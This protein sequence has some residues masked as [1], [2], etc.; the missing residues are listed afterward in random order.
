MKAVAATAVL[1]VL[2]PSAAREEHT[3]VTWKKIVLS[4]TF[5]SE[6]ANVGDFNKDGKLDVVS[7]PFWY[8]GPEFKK[9]HEFMPVKVFKKDNEYSNAFFAFTYDFNKDGWTDILIYGFP[10]KD[11]S[12]FENPQGKA[13]H[14]KKT[15]IFP[16]VDNESPQFE[17]VNGDKVPDILCST[18][19]EL[20]YV[21]I[22]DGKFHRIGEKDPKKYHKY[23][24][25]LGVG[26]INGDGRKDFIDVWGWWE[27]PASLE[28]DPVWKR[29]PAKFGTAG[30]QIY[31]TDVDGDGDSDVIGCLHAHGYGL[32][33]WEQVKADGAIEWKQHT[34]MNEKPEDSRYGVKFS[35]PHAIDLVDIDG[36]G[37]K[38]IVTGKRHFAHGSKGDKDPL[39]EPVL[40]WWR[41]VR[42]KDGVDFV[43]HLIDN[44]S[45]IGTQVL[46][47][48][49]NGDGFPDT[50]V[51]SK[52]GT[53]VCLQER[54]K[55]SREEWEKAQPKPL[56]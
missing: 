25:G 41:L 44:D 39:A 11:A 54:R 29:H 2:A 53:F 42:G 15:E 4:E 3:L 33:W 52:R 38:D 10:G 8:E 23:T 56:K 28:G 36:D 37:L 7:G 45:G 32:A 24:H 51:G 16:V 27:Q 47:T 30:A 26:D 14:W 31:A 9:A 1:L 49:V 50:V 6:G 40:Y 35:Q 5:T 22:A 18:G 46:A 43:P 21:T 19:G 20:G 48:D 17:D 34:L 55:V 13:G 12:W